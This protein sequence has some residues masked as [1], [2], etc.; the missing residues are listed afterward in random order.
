MRKISL[1]KYVAFNNPQKA[2]LLLR[3]YR[4]PKAKNYRDLKKKLRYIIVR[5]KD[6]AL[7]DIVKIHPDKELFDYANASGTENET[8]IDSN[9]S[10]ASGEKKSNACGCSSANSNAS[11][12]KKSCCGGCTASASGETTENK[13]ELKKSGDMFG[14]NK[15]ELAIGV[16]GIVGLTFVLSR[17]IK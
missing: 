7:Q 9:F 14:F 12:E 5:Y 13:T 3:K 4:V 2:Q 8:S 1:P 10:N 6:S 17:T 16:I 15:K 11:G